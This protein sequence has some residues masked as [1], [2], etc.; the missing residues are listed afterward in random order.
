MSRFAAV[1]AALCCTLALAQGGTAGAP[2]DA[3]TKPGAPAVAPPAPELTGEEL[4]KALYA[5]GASVG[6]SIKP[7]SLTK[8]E[9]AKVVE[10]LTDAVDE[11][12]LK[13]KLEDYGPK[14]QQLFE[15][16][17]AQRA[18]VEK[19]KAK[20]ILDKAAKEKGAE[21]TASGLVYQEL[22]KGTGA[23]P[24]P[25]DTVKVHYRGTLLDGT[26]F[27]SSYKRGEP[28]EFSLGGV[29]KCWTEGVAKMKVG[30]KAKLLCP[31]EIAY[32]DRGNPPVIPGGA[33]LQFEVELLGIKGK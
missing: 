21:K 24:T 8:A 3:P 1:I 32:G 28:I 29:I 14:V 9:L 7:F 26:E 12:T 22:T 13:V 4:N 27:D 23:Q 10:G 5:L 19:E 11:K 20:A 6:R 25:A 31:S 18:I 30:G 16:R 33:T 2:K 15:K 17:S